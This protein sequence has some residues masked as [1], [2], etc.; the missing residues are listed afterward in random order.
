LHTEV[1]DHVNGLKHDNRRC[2]LRAATLSENARNKGIQ[3]NHKVGLKG[4]SIID[5]VDM[6]R[7]GRRFKARIQTSAGRVH[8]GVFHTAEDANAA[9]ERA[10]EKYF[11]AFSRHSDTP[12]EHVLKDPQRGMPRPSPVDQSEVDPAYLDQYRR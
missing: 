9:Y 7:G 4:V 1:T 11:G 5:K 12:P 10:S 8:L 2:N 6:S 3:R